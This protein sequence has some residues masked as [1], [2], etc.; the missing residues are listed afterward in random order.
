M[1]GFGI[2]HPLPNTVPNWYAVWIQRGSS[3]SDLITTMLVPGSRKVVL[4]AQFV[5]EGYCGNRRK[6]NESSEG[7]IGCIT[8]QVKLPSTIVFTRSKASFFNKR[9]P[10][11]P[12]KKNRGERVY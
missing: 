2:P 9:S 4:A 8:R 6:V 5:A 1:H 3:G 7:S 12:V 10:E 11:R